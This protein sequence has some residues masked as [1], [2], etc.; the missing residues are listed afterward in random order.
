MKKLAVMLFWG[1]LLLQS[2][3]GC[4]TDASA[5]PFLVR[6]GGNQK[7]WT[8]KYYKSEYFHDFPDQSDELKAQFKVGTEVWVIAPQ[9]QVKTTVQSIETV[10][11]GFRKVLVFS[12]TPNNQDAKFKWTDFLILSKSP[13]GELE[14]WEK[15]AVTREDKQFASDW[16]WTRA[17]KEY[18][19]LPAKTQNFIMNG[20]PGHVYDQWSCPW[21]KP[22]S[23]DIPSEEMQIWKLVSSPKRYLLVTAKDCVPGEYIMETMYAF[24]EDGQ[25]GWKIQSS[26]QSGVPFRDVDNDGFPEFS[27][28]APVGG[29][30]EPYLFKLLPTYKLLA[31]G[32]FM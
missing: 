4:S 15:S 31:T 7:P 18:K 14:K 12:L 27:G 1:L 9:A 5:D 3:L 16:I 21:F 17:E 11:V 32:Y 10:S 20:T 26:S 28:C 25:M 2:V 8:F 22:G 13:I 29:T 30:C 23:K 24:V 19:K 6:Q